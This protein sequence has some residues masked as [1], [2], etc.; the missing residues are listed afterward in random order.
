MWQDVS[1]VQGIIFDCDGVLI[2]SHEA[3]LRF[4]SLILERMGLP[5]MDAAD[6]MYVH[7]HT[8]EES[9]ARVVPS[10]RLEEAFK[11]AREV[12]YRQV[13]DWVRPQP[14]LRQF[15]NLLH[16]GRIRCAV[17]T[18]RTNTLPLVLER[19][20]LWQYFYPVISASDVTWPKPHPESVF[21]VLKTWELAPQN[22]VFIGDSAVDQYTAEAAGIA[23]WAY[24]NRHLEA[25]R[26]IDDYWGLHENFRCRQP[27]CQQVVLCPGP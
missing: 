14:G 18:N 6:R 2:D 16:A 24:G 15:L 26:H 1:W 22:V 8:V 25:D 7:M 27:S 19:F 5:D 12:S 11:V 9:L 13:M 21:W 23:F 20:D 3:N 4:Y 17:S 10:D